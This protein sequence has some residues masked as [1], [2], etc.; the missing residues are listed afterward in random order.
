MS[1]TYIAEDAWPHKMSHDGRTCTITADMVR[2]SRLYDAY[3][4][5]ENFAATITI[6]Y[7]MKIFRQY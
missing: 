3:F 2:L 1:T 6:S 4:N 7:G 5:E